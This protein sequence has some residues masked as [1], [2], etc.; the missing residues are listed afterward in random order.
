MINPFTGQQSLCSMDLKIFLSLDKS[1]IRSK[2]SFTALP[3]VSGRQPQRGILSLSPFFSSGLGQEADKKALHLWFPSR[4]SQVAGRRGNGNFW[5]DGMKG[6]VRQWWFT[7]ATCQVLIRKE[8]WEG[9]GKHSLPLLA[10]LT[11]RSVLGDGPKGE[12]AT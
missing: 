4:Y 6:E 11:G 2:V 10:A 3:Q 12:T 8:Q 7:R 5:F 9:M 1:V